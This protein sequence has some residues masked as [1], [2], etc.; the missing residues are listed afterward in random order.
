MLDIRRRLSELDQLDAPD[1]RARIDRRTRELRSAPPESFVRSTG[2]WWRGPLIAFGTGAMVLVFIAVSMLVLRTGDS[3]RADE[4][5]PVTQTTIEVATTT[6]PPREPITPLE[7]VTT[8]T[9]PTEP[10]ARSGSG[11]SGA[12]LL[13]WMYA[14]RDVTVASDGSVYAASAAGIAVLDDAGAWTPIDTAGFPAGNPLDNGWPAPRI[15]NVAIGPDGALW[16][17]GTSWSTIDDEEFGGV[18][19]EPL[20]GFMPSARFK[21]WVA[22]RDC[23]RGTCAWTVFTVDVA[24][25]QYF[26]I[27]DMAVS[28]DGTV[29][30]VTG[31]NLLL[32]FDGAEW[33]SHTVPGIPAGFGEGVSPWS[34][35]LAVDSDGVV[36]IGTNA[37]DDPGW[38]R[39]DDFQKG[40]GLFAFD[41]AEFIRYTTEDGLPSDRSFQV[42][43]AEDGT[44]WVA[45]DGLDDFQVTVDEDG[46]EIIRNPETLPPEAAVGVARFDGVSWTPYTT[47]DGLLSN[48]ATL[49]PSS[50][51]TVWAVHYSVPQYG[52]THFDGTQ[53]TAYPID[54]PSGALRA[55]RAVAGADGTLW[56]IS[57]RGLVSFDGSTQTVH[58]SPVARP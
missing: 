35:S 24:P 42:T 39:P 14:V 20:G 22:R 23:G 51:G 41:G 54:P 44:I 6:T 13:D 30:V 56:T 49:A 1:M 40:R 34:S 47:A 38:V 29:Y 28:A 36:W 52:Y 12:T 46:N 25:G 45:T 18:V 4:P 9:S 10:D 16:A 8:T 26:D 48:N 11:W 37:N 32:V 50:D 55:F 2:S 21:T 53:W 15:G 57:D 17:G 31:D 43:V 7:P 19:A 33:E 3:E 58:P 27:G 5:A